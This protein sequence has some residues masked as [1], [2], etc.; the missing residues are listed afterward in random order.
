MRM[1]EFHIEGFGRLADVSFTDVPAGLSIVVGDNE[2]GKTTLLAFL[3]SV[4]FGLPSRK[5]K[6][7][8]PPLKGGRKGGR[9][10]LLDEPSDRI[11]VER[12]EGKGIG[13]LTV[14]FPNGSQ[15]GEEDFR[16]LIGSATADLYRNVFAFSLSE[17]QTLDS[18][19]TD[20]VRDAIYSAGVGVG[21]RTITEI[22]REL[23]KQFGDLFAPGGSK[24]AMNK[25]LSR[26]EILG[27]QI[28]SHEKDQDE[29]QR[30]QSELEA[31]EF[32][33]RQ[34]RSQ[35]SEARRR[36]QRLR[37]LRQA[38]DDWI[39]LGDNRD[40]LKTL[41]KI[42]SFPEDGVKR[43]NALSTERRGFLDQ[44]KQTRSAKQ[45]AEGNLQT[46]EADEA[47]LIATEEIRRLDRA[48]DRYDQTRQEHPSIHTERELA[49]E[50]LAASLRDLGEEWD[51]DKLREFD[52]SVPA[53][54]QTDTCCQA[55]REAKRAV[56]ERRVEWDQQ[57]KLYEETSG[58]EEEARSQL[59]L[60]PRPSNAL[61]VE[62][63]KRLQL[64][65]ESCESARRDLL[66]VEKQCETRMA[67]LVDTLRKIGPH[68][69]E[70]RLR[71]FD[72]SL[73]AQETV[74]THRKR[75][76]DLRSEHQEAARRARDA[77]QALE[78]ARGDLA[79]VEEVLAAMPEP[80]VKD[81][82]EL[83]ERKRSLRA[84][85]SQLNDSEQRK[86]RLLHLEE[87]KQDWDA[88]TARLKD[89]L[90]RES[91]EL[92]AWVLPVVLVAGLVGLLTL[93][94]SRG[95][96]VSGAIVF[97]L[98][99]LVGILLAVARRASDAREE[100]KRT[101]RLNE[102]RDLENRSLELEREIGELRQGLAGADSDV[103][104]RSQS[105]GMADL[106]DGRAI[107]EAEGLVERHL[108]ALQ[109]RR[110][111]EQK[112]DDAKANVA[113]A[114]EAVSRTAQTASE[115]TQHLNRAQEE[116]RKWLA[117]TGLPE[118]LPPENAAN[119]LATLDAA[120]E[121]LKAIESDR[122]R[123]RDMK[124]A[125]REYNQQLK[126]VA[127]T[128]GFDKR[129]PDDAGQAVD[130]LVARLDEHGAEV[131]AIDET[132]RRVE[133]AKKQ[134]ARAQSKTD[135]AEELYREAVKAEQQFRR[136]W[137]DLLERLG[138]RSSLAV[139]S[140]PQMLQ[141]I[142]R[143]RDQLGR[144]DELRKQERTSQ[145]ATRSYC[146]DARSL[147]RTVGRAEPAD[148]DVSRAVSALASEL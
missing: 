13:P 67:H 92:P 117:E 102:I 1:A 147:S 85:R 129:I 135:R 5:Q 81:E 72:T 141:A 82:A 93:G 4:L 112:R 77:D 15:G 28:K 133:E 47:L 126:S 30:I 23:K 39:V 53:R 54:E 63:I 146:R 71:E 109:R 68:W 94:I 137:T 8:Y 124:D 75:L 45:N 61:D 59:G 113:K 38:W 96:W 139:E 90:Q 51:E 65:R 52:L 31:S 131:R 101:D 130:F 125:I 138:L 107:D 25:L 62:G 79:R 76:S 132:S 50:K 91:F 115:K 10:V 87:R 32:G 41:P 136:Q 114:V 44:I 69:T 7:F 123:I 119:V 120:R 134:T 18:L 60:L 2:A 97:G 34:I 55:S 36:L 74:S 27:R 140:A 21:P 43:L 127:T 35:L 80:E 116:W 103:T 42:E 70:D 57:R 108:E 33:I 144:V 22:T 105:A 6:D 66:S 122:E 110:P 142:E 73:A 64:G 24:P 26:V 16:Q 20:K 143:A 86:T 56:R 11:I 37:L 118:T 49:E 58:F 84:L 99:V 29:Y 9:I 12:F 78:D 100:R 121:Q 83:T 89:D 3:R 128:S 95:D 104:A 48:L 14:T 46:I 88:Q 145:E 19:K 111:A 17:L 148:D 98:F 106:S 40:K